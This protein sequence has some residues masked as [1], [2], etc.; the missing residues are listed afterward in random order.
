VGAV[1]TAAVRAARRRLRPVQ[2]PSWW[3]DAAM[4]A[5]FVIVSVA[6]AAAPVRRLDLAI[7]NLAD[8]HR[9]P[10]GDT[11]AQIANRL[12]SGGILAG[13]TAALAL[14]LAWRIRSA[15]PLAP[16]LAA[17]LLTGI[18]IQPL[19]LFFHRAAPHSMLPDDIEVRLFSQPG[20][21]SYPS[22]HAVNTVV[23]YGVIALL[24]TAL[25]SRTASH[26]TA[27]HQITLNRTVRRWLR[28]A[29]PV[30]VGLAGTYLGFHWLTD[31]L[32]GICLGILIDRA[33]ARTPWPLPTADE[34]HPQP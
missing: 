10:V 4:V 27:S 28:V 19:K 6:L 12:G 17:F 9:P 32:A 24:L 3:F 7:R 11:I 15:W 1:A 34:R 18:V 31:M 33:L 8:A 30:I 16:V 21:L 23:W 26:R 22:G 25:L 5:G 29:P 20:G 2:P 13:V 14:L